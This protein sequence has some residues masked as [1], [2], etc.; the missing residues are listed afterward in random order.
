MTIDPNILAELENRRNSG[1]ASGSFSSGVSPEIQEELDLMRQAD[2]AQSN[3]LEAV[4]TVSPEQW[5]SPSTPVDKL[6]GTLE[7]AAT[8]MSS[9]VA[10]PVAG[11]V[12]GV[13]L[14][15]DR[16]LN[17]AVQ[18]I[19]NVRSAMTFQPRGQE[20]QRQMAAVGNAL[21]PV[22]DAIVGASES[23]GDFGYRTTGNPE[24]AAALYSLP[25]M[26]LELI[27]LKG[28]R[29]ASRLTPD[30]TSVRNSQRTLLNDPF[31]GRYSGDVAEVKLNR[32]G[33]VVPDPIGETL[34][35]LGVPRNHVAVITNSSPASRQ[36]MSNM[37]DKFEKGKSNNIAQLSTRM[38]DDIGQSLTRRLSSLQSQRRGLGNRL[39]FLVNN[40][41]KGQTLEIKAP[42]SDFVMNLADRFDLK[43]HIAA[44]GDVS[45]RGLDTGVIGT[46]GMSGVRNIINDTLDV[47]NQTQRNGVADA[48]TVH[49]LK[50]GLDEMIDAAKASEAGITG[51]AHEQLLNLRSGLNQAMGDAFPDYRAINSDL[52]GIIEV[53]QPFDKYRSTGQSWVDTKVSNVVGTALDNLSGDAGSARA[54]SVDVHNL[55]SL[56]NSRGMSFADDTSALI[57]FKNAV[58]STFSINQESIM[59]GVHNLGKQSRQKVIDF[60]ASGAVGNTFGITHDAASLV[61]LGMR[62]S[63]AAQYMKDL[64]KT[65]TTIKKALNNQYIF[66]SPRRTS[67]LERAGAVAG[68]STGSI[69]V[70]EE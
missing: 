30:A 34:V 11:I 10:E 3:A 7:T 39:D 49:K 18:T 29:T 57:D 40:Q 4:S 33:N 69:A 66:P 45:F 37:L 27:G 53:M 31:L 61:A 35:E 63:E 17:S 51:T 67:P 42:M 12:G 58:E 44:N 28:A 56:M 14:V 60:I 23:L 1:V 70:S 52:S 20:G 16:D 48:A 36:I 2:T 15:T 22:G 32:A 9:I 65:R 6:F 38:T 68:G 64:A 46:S 41:L 26:A 5:T 19:E 54:L 13:N 50:K 24:V 8:I 55:E 59:R 62:K 21:A 25:T 43:P 47:L